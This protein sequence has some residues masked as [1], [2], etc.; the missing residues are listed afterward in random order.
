MVRSSDIEAK[1]LRQ[2]LIEKL[3][4]KCEECGTEL[5]LE[6]DHI[7]G[8]DYDVRLLYSQPSVV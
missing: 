5:R 3:G 1:R 4:G 7:N 6:I 2:E 8:R